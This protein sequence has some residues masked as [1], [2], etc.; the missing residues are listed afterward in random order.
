MN[1]KIFSV[2]RL[3]VGDKDFILQDFKTLTLKCQD[4]ILSASRSSLA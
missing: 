2:A 3:T 4:K 1:T